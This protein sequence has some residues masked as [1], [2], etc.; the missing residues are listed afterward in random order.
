MAKV[1]VTNQTRGTVVLERVEV[2]GTIF[3]RMK[4]LLGRAGL[5]PGEGLLLRPANSVH[6][7]GMKFAIDV[8]F[9]DRRGV[10][11][12]IIEAMPPG[13]LSPLVRGSSF[14]IEAPAGELR[15]SETAAGDRL[16]L[17]ECC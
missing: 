10:V 9:V 1:R 2:A 4:G 17:E 16:V 14:V 13:R 12:R 6:T 5:S 7:V 11:R 15:K 8:A 3:T